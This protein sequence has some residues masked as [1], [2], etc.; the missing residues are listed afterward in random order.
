MRVFGEDVLA[1][2]CGGRRVVIADLT[3]LGPMKAI[4]PPWPAV[5]RPPI[6]PARFN[7]G[8]AEMTWQD[9]VPA[10]QR[11]SGRWRTLR[12]R[13]APGHTCVACRP[14]RKAS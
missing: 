2:P 9:D 4:Q 10:L 14:S 13:H 11:K 8:L 12:K 1:F 7:G 6:A 3:Q 5:H